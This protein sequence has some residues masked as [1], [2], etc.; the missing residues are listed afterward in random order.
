MLSVGVATFRRESLAAT[1][2]SLARQT[3]RPDRVIVADND[4]H[5]SARAL[6]E[7]AARDGL[8]ITYR[9]AP[10]RN[11]CIARNACLDAAAG[12]RLAFIDDDE[13]A[14]P[15]WLERMSA[16]LKDGLAGVSGPSIAVYPDDAPGWMRVLSP[17]SQTPP[18]IHGRQLTGHTANCLLDLRH[19]ALSGLRF[20]PR[21]GRTGGED[22]DYFARACRRGAVFGEAAACVFEPV[23]PERLD[24]AWLAARRRRAGQTW[25]ESLGPERRVKA[26]A[27]APKALWCRAGA[28]LSPSLL[29]RRRAWLRGLFHEGVLAAARGVRPQNHYGGAG[30]GGQAAPS[31]Q[32]LPDRSR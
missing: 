6:C 16:A 14:A 29:A 2:G 8:P 19:S 20:D 25:Y 12:G 32:T 15:D 17:H 5:P 27:A 3:L 26:V 11:I 4:E 9:H 18:R 24:E 28:A 30:E 23:P 21:F 7:A 22:A 31:S 1:L 13:T 10:A